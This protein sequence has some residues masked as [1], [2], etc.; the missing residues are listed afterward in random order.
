MSRTYRRVKKGRKHHRKY[1]TR[2]IFNDEVFYYSNLNTDIIAISKETPNHKT[3]DRYG[4]ECFQSNKL[5]KKEYNKR[6]KDNH[7]GIYSPPS[8]F[9]NMYFN[10]INRKKDKQEIHKYLRNEEYEP[11]FS[12]Y[13]NTAGWDW[14]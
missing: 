5:W 12:I 9:V 3:Y 13:R 8:W 7:T 11:I 14:W 6:H 1:F 4:Y 10:K 2:S